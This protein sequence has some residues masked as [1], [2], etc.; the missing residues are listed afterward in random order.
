MVANSLHDFPREL[1]VEKKGDDCEYDD[2]GSKRLRK[3]SSNAA[4]AVDSREPSI[5]DTR[6]RSLR[7]TV[8]TSIISAAA[9]KRKEG[10][11]RRK[12]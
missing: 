1:L 3:P 5:A 6:I 8:A 9:G 7:I 2:R 10:K 4:S 11:T 12:K